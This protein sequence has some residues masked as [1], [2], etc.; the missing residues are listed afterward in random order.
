MSPTSIPS[1]V[2]CHFRRCLSFGR[3]S[4]KR[5]VQ[6][7]FIILLTLLH[8]FP[9]PLS[10][11]PIVV[12]EG[13]PVV[14]PVKKCP[15][16]RLSTSRMSLLTDVRGLLLSR[17]SSWQIRV[18]KL[19]SWSYLDPVILKK[20]RLLIPMRRSHVPPKCG[21][22]GGI[23]FHAIFFDSAYFCIS[24]VVKLLSSKVFAVLVKYKALSLWILSGSPRRL[25][26]R[27]NAIMHDSFGK[28]LVTSI[29]TARIVR[30][31]NKQQ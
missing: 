9:V 25:K 22:P 20:S 15:G 3:Y 1:T 16:V 11:L 10:L 18:E 4:F 14:I 17:A 2:E 28:F 7:L 8:S 27:W 26:N 5:R 19:S 13:S 21:P 12:S 6:N 23:N 24:V 29:W 30:Q 31:V